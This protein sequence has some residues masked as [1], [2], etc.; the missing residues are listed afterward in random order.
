M[1][2]FNGIAV[3]PFGAGA[4][5]RRRCG[6][7]RRSAVRVDPPPGDKVRKLGSVSV[8][9]DEKSGVDVYVVGCIHGFRSSVRDIETVAGS[10]TSPLRAVM[11]EL[12][13]DRWRVISK[14][15]KDK[16]SKKLPE[17]NFNLFT[18]LQTPARLGGSG[19]ALVGAVLVG[20]SSIQKLSG[21]E[22]GLEFVCAADEA[23]RV[24]AKLV[25][26]DRPANETIQRLSKALD[27]LQLFTS[28]FQTLKL[29][30]PD[31]PPRNGIN[32]VSTFL[33]VER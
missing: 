1:L 16:R 10:V 13:E 33:N 7:V 8:V 20:I 32:F 19:P 11:I 31:L 9:R 30:L 26:G 3:V 14:L 22:P 2:A 6:S 23:R 29:L 24:G 12:C 21:F 4:G 28:P 5:V 18:L 25:L 27:P 17:E 15:T